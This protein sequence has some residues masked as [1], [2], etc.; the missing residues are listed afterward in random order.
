VY[1][2]PA[3][4]GIPWTLEG[5]TVTKVKT[6]VVSLMLGFSAIIL[7]SCSRTPSGTEG[8]VEV[9]RE[10]P[11]FKLPDLSGQVV[12]LD[13]YKGKIVMLDFWATWC[14]PCRMSM[15]ILENLQKEYPNDMTLLA[16]NLQ[17]PRDE[18]RNFVR[19]HDIHS[20]V[21]LDESGSV[22]ETYGAGAIP[23]QV[24]IDRQGI[25]RYVIVGVKSASELRKMINTIRQ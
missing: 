14:G 12:A 15:P 16:V 18:V 10:A 3:A 22:G 23:M 25:V 11:K 19:E 9:G 13:Q 20:R 7:S 24:L 8:T 5:E 6:L 17:E 21:V 2:S 1:T 4:I